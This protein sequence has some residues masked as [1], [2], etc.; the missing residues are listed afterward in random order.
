MGRILTPGGQPNQ[1]AIPVNVGFRIDENSNFEIKIEQ[2][3]PSMRATMTLD[4]A[5][6]L[7]EGI[8]RMVVTAKAGEVDLGINGDGSANGLGIA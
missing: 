1:L 7:A 6:V 4:Q 8:R 2:G 5:G 3:S